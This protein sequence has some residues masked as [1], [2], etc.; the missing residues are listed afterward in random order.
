MMEQTMPGQTLFFRHLRTFLDRYPDAYINKIDQKTAC[1]FFTEDNRRWVMVFEG[2]AVDGV[3]DMTGVGGDHWDERA[4]D[5]ME[6]VG[7]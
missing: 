4:Q 3:W 7:F 1:I 2:D 5:Q 6:A